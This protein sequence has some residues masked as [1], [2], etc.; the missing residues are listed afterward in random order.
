MH[1]ADWMPTLVS[2][3]M[4]KPDGWKSLVAATEPKY[5]LGDGMVSAIVR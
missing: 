1:G 2:M 3:A 4:G 5:E